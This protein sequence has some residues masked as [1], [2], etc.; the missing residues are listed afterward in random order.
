MV[1]DDWTGQWPAWMGS[2]PRQN[3]PWTDAE[4][5]RAIRMFEQGVPLKRIAREH[6]R[7]IG[8]ITS[9]IRNE[10]GD[11]KMIA[12]QR[13]RLGNRGTYLGPVPHVGV[14]FD[15]EIMEPG[16]WHKRYAAM[17]Q[18]DEMTT[19]VVTDQKASLRD[20]LEMLTAILER[21]RKDLA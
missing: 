3:A 21:I 12:I 13:D 19:K 2:M 14:L 16:E 4:E 5:R 10:I 6:G 20:D 9:R 18:R 17:V 7:A 15:A 8:G 11:E 1:N